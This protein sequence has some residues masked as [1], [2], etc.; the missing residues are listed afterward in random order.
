[1]AITA[2]MRTMI[3]TTFA[4]KEQVASMMVPALSFASDASAVFAM[5]QEFPVAACK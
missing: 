2:V 4:P 1:M 5:T 3:V